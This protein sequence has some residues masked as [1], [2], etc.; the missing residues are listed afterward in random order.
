L[1][2]LQ[3][4]EVL[5]GRGASLPASQRLPK[6]EIS[7]LEPTLH[8]LR[9]VADALRAKRLEN[10]AVELES[11]EFKFDIGGTVG[12]AP[13]A[14]AVKTEIH[15]MRI[16]AELMIFA[17]AAVADR[18]YASM[19]RAALL[20]RHDPPRREGMEEV[21]A[22]CARSTEP[23]PSLPTVTDDSVA[24][25]DHNN[26]NNDN[27]NNNN[28]KNGD[29]TFMPLRS[30]GWSGL[31]PAL[32][33]ACADT[34][35][36]IA[37]LIKAT[38]TRAMSEAQYCCAGETRTV[39]QGKVMVQAATGQGNSLGHFG[40]ALPLYTHFTSPIRRYAD[41]VVHRQLLA[42]VAML[43]TCPDDART[44]PHTIKNYSASISAA[45]NEKKDRSGCCSCADV[46]EKAAVMNERHRTAKR[47]QKSCANLYLLLV[48]HKTP[49]AE[50]AV[51][52]DISTDGKSLLVFVPK[53]HT[54]V[55]FLIF[56]SSL[57]SPLLFSH[58][59]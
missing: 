16:V 23:P 54:K 20:R 5:E 24:S 58:K 35:P 55:R 47:A 39:H 51:V 59:I 9:A 4:Q 7:R 6:A 33:A 1:E 28:T 22:L 34:S 44:A 18:I 38:A 2:Y 8:M 12:G 25:V 21:L 40:L 14:V 41:I 43:T 27:N 30:G 17:N 31:G 52:Y 42:V 53:Y 36:E 37:T 11:V 10:G 46:A 48:L 56:G 13:K 49:H 3:A 50:R 19:P 45:N 29:S 15:M 57:F 32:R 26:S